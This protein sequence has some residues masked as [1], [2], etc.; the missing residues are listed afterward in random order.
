MEFALRPKISVDDEQVDASVVSSD[1]E[2]FREQLGDLSYLE[3]R[4]EIALGSRTLDG[5]YS[6]PIV[7]L[8]WK[9]LNKVPWIISGDTETF[10]LRN[11]EHC[12]AFVPT[13]GN[14]EVSFFEGTEAEI[15]DYVIEPFN[16]PL[17]QFV[18][19]SLAAGERVVEV[20]RALAPELLDNN[21]DCKDLL[22]N[23]DEARK[24]WH[25]Y[26]VHERA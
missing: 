9:W 25:D 14:V 12:Y 5:D 4:L 21:E 16:V 24:A 18:K 1:A 3:G 8:L 20:V 10:A 17:E 7:R 19:A 13:A 6:D 2:R 22:V 11:S 26:E 15:E 23:L